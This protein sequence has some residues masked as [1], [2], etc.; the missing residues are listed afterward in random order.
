[1]NMSAVTT[2]MNDATEQKADELEEDPKIDFTAALNDTGIDLADLDLTTETID[3]TGVDKD[4]EAFQQDEFVRQAL[5]KNVN[6]GKYAKKIEEDLKQIQMESVRD[7]ITKAEE[8]V[9]LHDEIKNCDDLLAKM[10]QMLS[11]FQDHLKSISGEIK[12]L[13]DKSSMMSL[14][15]TNKKV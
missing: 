4:L 12:H 11:G 3:L 13:Q 14:Q 15:L 1:M 8:L 9:D 6:L 10:E 5:D 2:R 7:Y